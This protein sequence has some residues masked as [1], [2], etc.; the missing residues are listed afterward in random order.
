VRAVESILPLP[1]L[2]SLSGLVV[3]CVPPLK[4]ALCGPAAP[5]EFVAHAL[6][7]VAGATVP[8]MSFILGAALHRGPGGR[9]VVRPR[10]VAAV[11]AV[12]LVALP[13]LGGAVVLGTGV[14]GLWEALDPLFVFVLILINAAPTAP[15][16]Q[17]LASMFRANEAE[18]AALIFWQYV[19]YV[20]ALPPLIAGAAA[21]IEAAPLRWRAGQVT[22]APT[23]DPGMVR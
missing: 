4:R 22:L 3:G 17:A 20:V 16:V 19:A 18:T 14:A 1:A 8:I 21:V 11:V 12:R 23:N 6:H 15:A 2:L 13:L 5:L 9:R 7:T 10:L